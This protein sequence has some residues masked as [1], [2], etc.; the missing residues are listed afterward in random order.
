LNFSLSS[1][2]NKSGAGG[3]LYNLFIFS[4]L[5]ITFNLGTLLSDHSFLIN[6]LALLYELAEI[7][8]LLSF[9]YA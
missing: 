8:I 3:I 6:I 2:S 9:S 1:N 4:S 5:F 7:I